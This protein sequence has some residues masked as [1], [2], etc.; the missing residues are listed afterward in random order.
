MKHI[1]SETFFVIVLAALLL[2]L[3]NPLDL[4]M[5][6]QFEM[7]CTTL[8]FIFFVLFSMYLLREKPADERE[9]LH[10]FIATRFA[11]LLGSG[12]LVLG[13]IIQTKMHHL[14]FWLPLALGAMLIGKLIGRWY[15]EKRH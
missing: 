3:I 12:I 11:Y 14:T 10:L 7:I 6:E 15:A 8:V 4:W 9:E 2:A 13:I 5:P 1:R